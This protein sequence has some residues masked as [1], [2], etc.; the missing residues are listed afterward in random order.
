LESLLGRG[1]AGGI[2]TINSSRETAV[3]A[4]AR[5]PRMAGAVQRMWIYCVCPK[6]GALYMVVLHL[7]TYL[8]GRI[9]DRLVNELEARGAP[10][11]PQRTWAKPATLSVCVLAFPG[12]GSA[13]RAEGQNG[14]RRSSRH[15][16][17]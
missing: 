13:S 10:R 1:I 2:Q 4:I 8:G 15:H 14:T 12:R 6:K 7:T 17:N 11:V 9:I 5:A 3:P 16:W